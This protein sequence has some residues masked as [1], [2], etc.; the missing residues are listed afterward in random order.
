MFAY[1]IEHADRDTTMEH[2]MDTFNHEFGGDFVSR[3][4]E[5]VT[6]DYNDYWKSFTVYF[7]DTCVDNLFSKNMGFHSFMDRYVLYYNKDEFWNVHLI[8]VLR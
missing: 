5:S 4:E 7:N 8:K 6:A 2:V 3:V 1:F